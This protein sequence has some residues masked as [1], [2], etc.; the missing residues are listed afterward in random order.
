V[1]NLKLVHILTDISAERERVSI[2]HLK[3][4]SNHGIE[5]IQQINIPYTGDEYL[6]IIPI[7]GGDPKNYKP[8]HW[9]AFQSFKK[10]VLNNFT[11]DIDGLILCECDCILDITPE[12]FCQL[13][14]RASEFCEK[15]Q[16]KY[17][18]F[19]DTTV[20]GTLQSYPHGEP[21]TEYPE[22]QITTK[23][24][25]AHCV[26]LPR[27]ARDYFLRAYQEF[28]WESPDVWLNEAVWRTGVSSHAIMKKPV[29]FQHPGFSLIDN[30]WKEVQ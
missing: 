12:M 19:G 15:H 24:I 1:K 23:I 29:A 4:V 2:S 21:D 7:T 9:G 17:F 30:T 25:L 27:H 28:S 14:H 10:A 18:S 13:A 3:D 16:I 6:S 8:G 20:G 22:F 11:D 5:Y 26:L